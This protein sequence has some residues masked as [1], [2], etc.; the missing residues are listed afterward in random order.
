MKIPGEKKKK[1][2]ESAIKTFSEKS[3]SGSTVAEIAKGAGIGA[4]GLYTYF[5]TKEKILFTII[6]N[7][8]DLS[9][10]QLE[11]HL[12]G[13]H[14]AENK[15]RKAIWFHC[16]SY[17]KSKKEIKIILEARSYPEFYKSSAYISLKN[18]AKIM[19]D[20]IEQGMSEGVFCKIFSPATLRDVIL[21]TVDHIAINWIIKDSINSLNQAEDI[22]EMV[23]NAVASNNIKKKSLN[24][25]EIKKKKIID[26]A[27]SI[28]AEKG[29]GGT[30]M[31]EVA[32]RA[33]VGEGT[34]YDYY[35]NKENLLVNIPVKK[36]G[37]LYGNISEKKPERRIKVI[38]SE[39][40]KFYNNEKNYST[41]LVFMLRT[42]KKFHKSQ[43]NKILDDIFEIIKDLIKKGQK[44]KIFRENINFNLCRDFIFG[45]IDH[46]LIPWIIFNRNYDLIKMGEEFSVLF[47]NAIKRQ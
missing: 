34:V 30:S 12:E 9:C 29:L 41:I 21:G 44:D 32:K 20:I 7:F 46:I 39:I 6:E 14:S 42:N 23:M 11:E 43:S 8:L 18:Y 22:Y 35:K 13:I 24:K 15:L 16:N 17:S 3:F 38:I 26:A 10:S 36:F 33:G 25:K 2:L 28:F 5:K 1:I 45:T 31:L 4:S 27:T 47:I 37:D 19:T 40:F